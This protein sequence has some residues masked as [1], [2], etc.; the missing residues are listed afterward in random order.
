MADVIVEGKGLAHSPRAVWLVHRAEREV[1]IDSPD[2]AREHCARGVVDDRMQ[3]VI[4]SG[5]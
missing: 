3:V 4:G 1:R 2:A 5:S